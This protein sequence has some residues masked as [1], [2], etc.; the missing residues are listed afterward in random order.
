[1]FQ[2]VSFQS[3]TKHIFVNR[4]S[5]AFQIS[6]FVSLT[7]RQEVLHGVFLLVAVPK[8]SILVGVVSVRAVPGNQAET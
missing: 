6:S 5:S 4:C 3:C 7:D 8:H 1:M 2:D